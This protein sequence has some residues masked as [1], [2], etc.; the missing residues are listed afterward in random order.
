MS[1]YYKL[2]AK[3]RRKLLIR[4][5]IKVLVFI[6]ASIIFLFLFYQSFQACMEVFHNTTYCILND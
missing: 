4:K 3:A 2:S 6:L 5:I 1:I